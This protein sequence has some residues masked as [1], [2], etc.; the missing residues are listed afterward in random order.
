VVALQRPGAYDFLYRNRFAEHLRW[1]YVTLANSVH[2]FAASG[3]STVFVDRDQTH[4][5]A[6]AM[7]GARIITTGDS[8]GTWL[9]KMPLLTSRMPADFSLLVALPPVN[10]DE[11]GSRAGSQTTAD[12]PLVGKLPD[13]TPLY[14]CRGQAGRAPATPSVAAVGDFNGDGKLDLLWRSAS[15]GEIV[16]WYLDGLKQLGEGV[17]AQ[18]T[19]PG[20]EWQILGAADTDADGRSELF[21]RSRAGLVC[22]WY[23]AAQNGRKAWVQVQP[24]IDTRWYAVAV[25]DF[26]GDGSADV[27]WQDRVTGNVAVKLTRG[28]RTT[29]TVVTTPPGPPDPLWQLV[30]IDDMDGDR[31]RDLLWQKWS[32]GTVLIWFMSGFERHAETRLDPPSPP[33]RWRVAGSGDFDGDGRAEIV[34]SNVDTGTIRIVPSGGGSHVEWRLSDSISSRRAVARSRPG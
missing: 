4:L 17:I 1:T 13:G 30:G 29:K 12:C 23:V 15:S 22:V 7:A 11:S 26:Q 10:G 6:A 8:I 31:N 18:T 33:G 21:C 19:A 2:Y 24:S 5:G 9:G 28:L 16:V 34:W 14:G 32:S 27:V 25:G 3:S 20:P